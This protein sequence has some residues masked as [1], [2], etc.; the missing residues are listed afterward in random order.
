MMGA[1]PAAVTEME[2]DPEPELDEEPELALD[3]ELEPELE[4]ELTELSADVA[5][6][7]V[8]GTDA[9]ELEA[10]CRW[11]ISGMSA[12][13]AARPATKVI[14]R[15][16]LKLSS[17][18]TRTR[19]KGKDEDQR[20]YQGQPLVYYIS[21]GRALMSQPE[22]GHDAVTL[23]P[24]LDTRTVMKLQLRCKCLLFVPSSSCQ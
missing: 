10:A 1:E 4:P 12:L 20:K 11:C 23:N 9:T 8:V 18:R 3:S 16:I 14:L 5:D 7:A 22:G 24:A 19:G 6:A 2:L 21:L 17:D 15:Y 13:A